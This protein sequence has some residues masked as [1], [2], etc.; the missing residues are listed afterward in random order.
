MCFAGLKEVFRRIPLTKGINLEEAEAVVRAPPG[1]RASYPFRTLCV[2]DDHCAGPSSGAVRFRFTG[3][4]P[5][6]TER[7]HLEDT[8]SKRALDGSDEN[9]TRQ[10]EEARASCSAGG[11]EGHGPARSGG[12]PKAKKG[13]STPRHSNRMQKYGGFFG[14]RPVETLLRDHLR[15]NESFLNEPEFFRVCFE[16][17]GA[18]LARNTWKRYNSALRLWNRSERKVGKVLFSWIMKLGTRDSSFGGGG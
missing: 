4:Q 3:Q 6:S 16:L 12:L 15:K 9:R 10:G 13:I 11:P 18:S 14:G 8:R 2:E 7:E 1:A 5:A 17:V